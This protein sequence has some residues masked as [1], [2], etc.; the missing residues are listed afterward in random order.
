MRPGSRSSFW[1]WSLRDER[2]RIKA[3]APPQKTQN[4]SQRVAA[5]EHEL[6]R[7]QDQNRSFRALEKA[8]KQIIL[9]EERKAPESPL[10]LLIDGDNISW[11]VLGSLSRGGAVWHCNHQT[12]LR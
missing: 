7:L 8:L 1:S 2:D 4:I 10:A 11:R 12:G 5:L 3:A 6:Q 9:E